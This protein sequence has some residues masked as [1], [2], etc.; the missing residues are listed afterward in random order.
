MKLIVV[1]WG[2]LFSQ[3]VMAQCDQL[4]ATAE[5][6]V[7]NTWKPGNSFVQEVNFASACLARTKC[8][9]K[10]S[11]VR[12]QC[13]DDYHKDLTE[14][15]RSGFPLEGRQYGRCMKKINSAAKLVELEGSQYFRAQKRKSEALKREQERKARAKKRKESSLKRADERRKKRLGR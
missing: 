4:F 6:G 3:V 5:F 8:Y 13:D 2:L 9:F 10:N 7:V 1:L 14:V 15:C 11:S 12:S